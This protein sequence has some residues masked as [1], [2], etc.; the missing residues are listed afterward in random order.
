MT[1]LR[2]SESPL[3][4]TGTEQDGMRASLRALRDVLEPTFNIR[5]ER[6]NDLGVDGTIEVGRR[7]A[8]SSQRSWTNLRAYFQIKHTSAPKFLSDGSLSYPIEVK[9]LN[10]LNSRQLPALYV[11]LDYLANK[12]YMRWHSHVIQELAATNPNWITQKTVDVHFT[13]LL[14][15]D[16]LL[17]IEAEIR[18]QAEMVSALYDGPGFIRGFSAER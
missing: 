5:E 10:Y 18:A 3:P 13:Q 16:L 8:V 17:G 7:D 12:L 9:N 4:V 6:E 1:I 14:T 2:D 11:V 15:R